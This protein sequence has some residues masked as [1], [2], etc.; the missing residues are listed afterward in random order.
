[1]TSMSSTRFAESVSMPKIFSGKKVPAICRMSPF[2]FFLKPKDLLAVL[3]ILR[4]S[5]TVN[6][7]TA[8]NAAFLCETIEIYIK[9][10]ANDTTVRFV[11]LEN[12]IS[13]LLK[14][15]SYCCC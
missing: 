3:F 12:R 1:M 2:F 11:F 13:V 14:P 7:R 6:T 4:V 9:K 5:C 10:L 15:D 8:T